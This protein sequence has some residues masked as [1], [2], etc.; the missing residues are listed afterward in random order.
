MTA[1]DMSRTKEL[2]MRI[3][4]MNCGS[5]VSRVRQAILA[6]PGAASADVD[7]ASQTAVAR[8]DQGTTF[9]V[10][11]QRVRQGGYDAIEIKAAQGTDQIAEDR[12][13]GIRLRI[14]RQAVITALM[15]GLPV[16]GLEL[17][18]PSLASS[19]EGG[20]VW[21]RALQAVLCAMVLR[22]PAGGPIIAG[23][24]RAVWL[25]T[26]N[27]DL[28]ITLG[29]LTAFVSSAVAI[30]ISAALH[31]HF[32]AVVMILTFINVGRYIEAKARRGVTDS[33]RALM[34]RVPRSA[35]RVDGRQT[36]EVDVGEVR[37]GDKLQVAADTQVPVD[38]VV[39]SG[40]GAV[41]ESMLTG[42]STPVTK[43]VGDP[44]YGGTLLCSGMLIVEAT[45]LGSESAIGQIIAAV[46]RAQ[47]S[48]TRMQRFADRVAAVFVPIVIVL[49]V[50]TL[51][52]WGLLGTE[53][54]R[55]AAGLAS[56]VAVL[57]IACPCALGLAT[58]T[59]VYVAAARAGIKGVLVKDAAALERLGQVEVVVFD[60]TGTITSGRAEV[61]EVVDEPV[62][63][64]AQGNHDLLRLAASVEQLSQH[65]L[66][67]AIVAEARRCSI[68]LTQPTG[69]QNDPGLGARGLIDEQEVHVGNREYLRAHDV[70]TE[71]MEPRYQQLCSDG[72]NVV[73]VASGGEVAGLIGLA[74][75]PRAQAGPAMEDLR[76]LGID[77]LMVTGDHAEAATYVAGVVG[78]ERVH[79]G[80]KPD[81]KADVIRGLQEDG[82][83]VAFVGDGINDAPAIVQADVGIAFAAG[84]D[85]ANQAAEIT[86]VGDDLRLVGTTIRLGQRSLA[87]IKQNLFWAFFY[88]LL[89]VPLA[90]F[91]VIPAWAAPAAMMFSSISVVLNSLRLKNA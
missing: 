79:A 85:V 69:F 37:V 4:G 76:S 68:E 47:L 15:Y 36:C 28:L 38:G 55:W 91:A 81:E 41:D 32:H 26:P 29:V 66:A 22:S 18:G 23:G 27:M 61:H 25:R 33:V 51:L 80:K 50:L 86:L 45:R 60:K 8:V 53:S 90:A 10:V 19:S 14:G 82:R 2:H 65:P 7:L 44:A 62:G 49:A 35:I 54:G 57:V 1:D 89:A 88:N 9:E 63:P 30:F 48:R 84:T 13:F 39:V 73:W 58:P 21:W 87:I 74:D 52:G 34:Q 64:A 59:A 6:I 78:I 67:K 20:H 11:A 71:L 75:Q 43:R 31:Y 16:I 83:V 42:E 70:E 56:A 5:C 46:R 40:D 72:Q 77:V 3:E 12:E 24:L 17:F